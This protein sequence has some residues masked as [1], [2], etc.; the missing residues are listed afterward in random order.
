MC[1]S[2]GLLRRMPWNSY[3]LNEDL[4]YGLKLLL[5]GTPVTFAPEALV[6]ATMPTTPKNAE[7]QRSRWERGRLPVIRS[8]TW[9][10]AL[11]ALRQ[12]SFTPI[13]A[14]IDLVTPPFVNLFG[15][16]GAATGAHLLL[17][18]A[19]A[20]VQSLLLAWSLI[21]AA[22]VAHVLIGLPAAGADPALYR[23][24]L[25]IPRYALWKISLY[26]RT[27]RSRSSEEW[28]RTTREQSAT[29][30]PAASRTPSE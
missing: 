5:N 23:A 20:P 14:L 30:E 15:G 3:S 16:V 13:D 26:A 25:Y 1:F 18:A 28:V 8:Y 7:S 12:R 4:E 21:L 27:L 19:G 22:L 17:L 11:A 9:P 10:L 2:A 6:H 24:F 29:D